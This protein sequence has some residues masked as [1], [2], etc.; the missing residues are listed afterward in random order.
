[1]T[2]APPAHG[3]DETPIGERAIDG[4]RPWPGA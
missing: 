2:G 1:M 4:A 3:L